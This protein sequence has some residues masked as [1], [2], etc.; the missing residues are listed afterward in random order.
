MEADA[1]VENEEGHYDTITM[2]DLDS[3]EEN[4]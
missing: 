3:T 4:D 1:L 2:I